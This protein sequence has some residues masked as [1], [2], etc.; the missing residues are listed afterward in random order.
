MKARKHPSLN[1]KGEWEAVTDDIEQGVPE[2]QISYGMSSFEAEELL[3]AYGKNELPE[4]K[5]PKW[6]IFLSL[7]WEPMPIMI[8]IA[9]IIEAILGK[10]MDMSIL[11]AIQIANA[12]IAFYETTKSGDA[13][14]ALKA[15]LR[16]LA[17]VKRDDQ[18][19]H[20][21]A[22]FLVPGDLISLSNGSAVPADVRINHGT[23]EVDQ[24]ALT[25]ESLPVTKFKGDACRMGSTIVRG[26]VEATVEFTGA[27]TF[28]GKTASLLH[29]DGELSSLQ[30][31][32]V[33]IMIV[34]VVLSITLCA[35]VY[36]HL[37]HITSVVEALSFTVVLFVASI[38]LAI[39]IVTTTTLALGSKELSK[40][41]AI[42]TRLSAIEDMAGMSILCSDKTGTLTLNKMQLHHE[43]P[44]YHKGESQYSILRYAAMASKWWEPPKDALDTLTLSSVD[45]KSL[46]SV[47]QIEYMPFDPVIKRTEGTIR[48]RITG[49]IFKTSKG[50]PHVILKLVNDPVITEVVERDIKALGERGIRSLAVAKTN[51]NDDW[52]MLGILTFLDPPRPDTLQTIQDARHYGVIVKMITGDHLLIAKET[53]RALTLGTKIVP[54]HV[55]PSL[56]PITHQKPDHLSRDYGKLILDADGFAEVFPEHKYLIVECLREMGYKTGMTGDGVNDAPAL[57]RADIGIAVQGS[58]DA[59]RA[60]ADIVLTQ[61]GLSTIIHGI[62]IARC[63]FVRIQNFITY[64]IAATL[65][66]LLFF[67]IAIF[68]Y[69]PAEYEPEDMDD[70]NWPNF[71]HMPVIMLMLITLLNDGTLIAIGYDNVIPPGLPTNWNL[72]VL[73]VVGIVL[74]GVACMSSLLLLYLSLDSWQ[75]NS[76]YQII[77]LGG[78]SYGQITTSIFLKVAVSDF[79]TL[80][81][82]RAGEG[83][84]W[85]SKPSPILLGAAGFALGMST[86]FACVWPMSRPD[87][88]PTLGLERK[89]PLILPVWIW[90]Y[91]IVWW[92]IQ[93]SGFYRLA[94]LIP[95][96][97][98]LL[99]VFQD[100]AKVYTYKLLKRYNVFGYND[101]VTL[102]VDRNDFPIPHPTPMTL[103]TRSRSGSGGHEHSPL[104]PGLGSPSGHRAPHHNTFMEN[105]IGTA[106]TL[107]EA[108]GHGLLG[109]KVRKT[110]LYPSMSAPDADPR[111]KKGI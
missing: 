30:N 81:S 17:T 62:I 63:I 56:D 101:S 97:I 93:V 99:F 21:D 7:F 58:T 57:K 88:I 94:Y 18:W 53:S 77:G 51:E 91:C 47:E 44:I 29:V 48:D 50:A 49:H 37:A 79:L 9:I 3:N 85:S 10:W 86:V 4:K 16:P 90:L 95:F 84:F 39:E 74:A 80:F 28:F 46:I 23:V 64:R 40:H 25:G 87:G 45:L 20:I 111:N 66:L 35:I 100:A 106:E 70:H 31:V 38:P 61:P 15:S 59:A 76:F 104:S 68:A 73:F 109:G 75:K 102:V 43:C 11:L 13:V 26:E 32:L 69:R 65:Q 72:R 52:V 107:A 41:G 96:L 2:F 67:F 36:L 27:R 98:L 22:S 108:T 24:A 12:S 5:I 6:Y 103:L 82:A 54:P 71:F 33:D 42:V 1:K 78:I 89:E 14:A 60:A 83:W 55:L 105:M 34:L 92:F 19:K 8:W 110:Q